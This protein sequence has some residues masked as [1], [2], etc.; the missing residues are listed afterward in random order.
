MESADPVLDR[1][2]QLLRKQYRCHTIILYGSRGRGTPSEGS[3]YDV[4]GVRKTGKRFRIARKERG[5]YLDIFVFPEK[6]LRSI[7][8]S[9]LYMKDARVIFQEKLF[10]TRLVTKLQKALRKGPAL[11]PEDE[12]QARRVWSCKMLERARQKDIEGNFRRS[13]LQMA[14]LEDYFLLRGKRFLGS[15]ASFEWLEMNDTKTFKLYDRSLKNPSNLDILKRLID[16]VI[17]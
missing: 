6:D 12:M 8:E 4:M 1:I 10:G 3:D 11:L 15:K 5:A 17:A 2:T 16:R 14:L 13:W 9:L 7:D